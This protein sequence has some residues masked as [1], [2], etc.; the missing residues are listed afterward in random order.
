MRELTS[1]TD[2]LD[3]AGALEAGHVRVK[4]IWSEIFGSPVFRATMSITCEFLTLCI[5]FGGKISRPE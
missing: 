3:L 2:P 4:E 5:Q 1:F